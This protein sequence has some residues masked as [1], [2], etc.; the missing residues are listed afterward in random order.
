MRE[1]LGSMQLDRAVGA[2]L[3][4]ATGDALGAGYEFGRPC[5]ACAGLLHCC[6]SLD[7]SASPMAPLRVTRPALRWRFASHQLN[8]EVSR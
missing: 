4:L 1:K 5:V 6:G 3:G 7:A 8:S 2:L